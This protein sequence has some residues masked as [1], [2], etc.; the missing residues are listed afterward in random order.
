MKNFKKI[1]SYMLTIMLSTGLYISYGFAKPVFLYK[2]KGKL[3]LASYLKRNTEQEFPL[4]HFTK[5][6]RAAEKY[7]YDY[8]QHNSD[9]SLPKTYNLAERGESTDVRDQ[10]YHGTCWSFGVMASLESAHIKAGLADKSI[11]LSERHLTCF[12]FKPEIDEEGNLLSDDDK[13]AGGDTWRTANLQNPYANGGNR[14]FAAPT[15]ARGFGAVDESVAKYHPLM[16]NDLDGKMAG[17]SHLLLKEAVYLKEPVIKENDEYKT[18]DEEANIEIKKALMKDGAV[19]V[20]Y[21]HWG[22]DEFFNEDTGAYYCYK[23][24]RGAN[25]QVCIVGWDDEYS[26]DNFCEKTPSHKLPP[27]KGAWIIKNSWGKKWG[28]KGYFYLSYYDKSIWGPAVFK[29]YNVKYE[30]ADTKKPIGR[31]YQYDGVGLG[32]FSFVSDMEIKQANRFKLKDAER[33]T[34]V[35]F[36]TGR[37]NM[38]VKVEL[39]KNSPESN[40]EKGKPLGNVSVF[41]KNPGYHVVKLNEPVDV[42]KN[43]IIYA[44]ISGKR[45]SGKK[46]EWDLLLETSTEVETPYFVAKA[47]AA[48][49]QTY[50]NF[51]INSENKIISEGHTWQDVMNLPV[52]HEEIDGFDTPINFGNASIKLFTDADSKPEVLNPSQPPQ[53]NPDLGTLEP[54]K[55]DSMDLNMKKKNPEIVTLAKGKT[56]FLSIPEEIDPESLKW[57]SSDK[58][59]ADVNK[60]GKVKGKLPGEVRIYG[61]KDESTMYEYIVR[62][63]PGQVKDFK[64]KKLGKGFFVS[65]KIPKGADGAVLYLGEKNN[66]G[67]YTYRKLCKASSSKMR[68]IK[69]YTLKRGYYSFQVRAYKKMPVYIKDS[70]ENT[71]PKGNALF[72]GSK[73]KLYGQIK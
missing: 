51:K 11:D 69:F 72:Y 45:K 47:S 20:A 26:V 49:G 55:P 3:E 14:E 66:N 43:E 65:W 57:S 33:F 64:I 34:S 35:G 12:T 1:I 70:N 48:K 2:D 28:K 25:H 30:G 40:P 63:L 68:I 18:T 31:I 29:G 24:D 15:L 44:V 56:K 13:Y 36:F 21:H 58:S 71:V 53:V 52:K 62:I 61:R 8:K 42:F 4:T 59:L 39:Y 16:Q 41:E 22:G 6:G 7:D 46:D 32:D 19:T 5:K 54:P 10:G 17:M 23:N 37:P 9:E 27:K 38:D 60:R 73:K 67:R 50:V